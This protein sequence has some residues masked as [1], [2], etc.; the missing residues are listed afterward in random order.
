MWDSIRVVT[1]YVKGASLHVRAV[2]IAAPARPDVI[3]V[4]SRS[5]KQLHRRARQIVKYPIAATTS[6]YVARDALD[7]MVRLEFPNDG[8]IAVWQEDDESRFRVAFNVCGQPCRTAPSAAV[9]AL[10]T[11]HHGTAIEVRAQRQLTP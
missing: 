4:G 11:V 10:K 5:T 7:M 9:D 6:I 8:L 3:R 2:A 1:L